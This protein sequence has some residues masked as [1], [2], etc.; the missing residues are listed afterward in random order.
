MSTIA[1][2]EEVAVEKIESLPDLLLGGV[3]TGRGEPYAIV[4]GRTVQKGDEIEG[5]KIINIDDYG[6]TYLFN[7]ERYKIEM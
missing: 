6:I 2:E 3:V 5:A 1:E 7:G 4:N